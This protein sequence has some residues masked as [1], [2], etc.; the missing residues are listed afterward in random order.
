MTATAPA[1][2]KGRVR[3]SILHTQNMADNLPGRKALMD[4]AASISGTPMM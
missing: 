4:R 3:R 2:K 1:T